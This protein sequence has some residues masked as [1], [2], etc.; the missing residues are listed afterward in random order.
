MP[1]PAADIAGV[2][3]TYVMTEEEDDDEEG[4]VMEVDGRGHRET[5]VDVGDVLEL[6][7]DR[8]TGSVWGWKEFGLQGCVSGGLGGTGLNIFLFRT[9]LSI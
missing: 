1:G 7:V 5:P 4:L 2:F 8:S 9:T 3:G 6:L